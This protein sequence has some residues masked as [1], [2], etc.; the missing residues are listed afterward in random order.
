MVSGAAHTPPVGEAAGSGAGLQASTPPFALHPIKLKTN[1]RDKQAI[2]L[3]G[4]GCITEEGNSTLS[5]KRHP[6]NL[7]VGLCPVFPLGQALLLCP[8]RSL[9]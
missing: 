6:R 7:S 9:G 2:C 8:G 5:L 1:P 4:G 3:V